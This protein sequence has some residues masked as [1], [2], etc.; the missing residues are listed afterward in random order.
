[1]AKWYKKI[2]RSTL[3]VALVLFYFEKTGIL[4]LHGICKIFC[5]YS[6]ICGARS[7][8]SS[9]VS[10]SRYERLSGNPKVSRFVEDIFH[11]NLTLPK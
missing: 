9:V 8:L 2:R 7:S 5:L 11:I 3:E 10:L 1:M 6:S 4:L